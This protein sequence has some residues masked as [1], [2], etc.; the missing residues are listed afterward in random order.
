MSSYGMHLFGTFMKSIKR[1]KAW[2]KEI[3]L[4]YCIKLNC[5]YWQSSSRIQSIIG[6]KKEK[7]SVIF[8]LVVGGCNNIVICK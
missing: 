7:E 5:S 6:M 2:G 1:G 3:T 8:H 4:F